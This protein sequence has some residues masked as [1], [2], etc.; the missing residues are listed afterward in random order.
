MREI[1][2]LYDV[3][4]QRCHSE[5][6]KESVFETLRFTQGDRKGAKLVVF[7]LDTR[8]SICASYDSVAAHCSSLDPPCHMPPNYGVCRGDLL[9]GAFH[10]FSHGGACA[11]RRI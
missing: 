7:I 6:S 2:I 5:R 10:R 4:S 8:S 1:R 3:T 9:D 11:L